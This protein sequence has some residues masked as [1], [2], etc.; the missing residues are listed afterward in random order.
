MSEDSLINPVEPYGASK[1]MAEQL[2]KFLSQQGL[3]YNALRYFNVYGERQAAH[4]YYTTVIIA[5]IKRI[6][7]GQPPVIDGKGDQSM[8][9][10]HVSDVVQANILAMK[11]KTVNEAFNVGTGVSTTVARLAQILIEAMGADLHPQFSGRPSLVSR[12]QGDTSKAER[13]LGFTARVDVRTGLTQ[14]ARAIAAHP[15][16]Y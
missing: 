5:F 12:R 13:L 1:W 9:F 10:T 15:E 14:V 16:L 8:D 3:W 6:L 11:S 4:A 2:L 7:N